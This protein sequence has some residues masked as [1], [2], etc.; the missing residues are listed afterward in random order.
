MSLDPFERKIE[1]KET[2]KYSKDKRKDV[3]RIIKTTLFW[4]STRWKTRRREERLILNTWAA[5][6]HVNMQVAIDL[7]RSWQ[8]Q[9]TYDAMKSAQ[10]GM[11][12]NAKVLGHHKT[13][14][15]NAY[16]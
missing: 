16:K 11:K 6:C 3:A 15:L 10:Q 7:T 9:W 4:R 5:N 14:F 13:T 2:K 12:L 8:N 1:L